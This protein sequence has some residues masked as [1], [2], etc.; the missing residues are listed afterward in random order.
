MSAVWTTDGQ[1]LL[2]CGSWHSGTYNYSGVWFG[3]PEA[4]MTL[5]LYR[6]AF[7]RDAGASMIVRGEGHE[8]AVHLTKSYSSGTYTWQFGSVNGDSGEITEVGGGSN[9]GF[10]STSYDYGDRFTQDG[11]SR[12]VIVNYNGEVWGTR[13]YRSTEPSRIRQGVAG[14]TENVQALCVT[15]DTAWVVYYSN[16]GGGY[17][18]R[19]IQHPFGDAREIAGAGVPADAM[20]TR[21]RSDALGQTLAL[22]RCYGRNALVGKDSYVYDSASGVWTHLPGPEELHEDGFS[23]TSGEVIARKAPA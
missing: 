10:V 3:T 4:G 23:S 16:L 12:G 11:I 1:K 6:A 5:T 8:A 7:A 15:G 22:A 21:L 9:T 18:I 2:V 13:D 17:G 20:F 19:G 14:G